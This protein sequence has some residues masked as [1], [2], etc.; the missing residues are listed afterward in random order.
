MLRYEIKEMKIKE[1]RDITCMEI[2]L[3]SVRRK[4]E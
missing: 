1:K 2:K 3:N 4:K